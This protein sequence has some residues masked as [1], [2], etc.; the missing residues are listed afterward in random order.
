MIRE[1]NSGRVVPQEVRDK[2]SKSLKGRPHT[3]SHNKKVSEALK[4]K[5]TGELSSAYGIKRSEKTRKR[6]SESAKLGW[7]KRKAKLN[8]TKRTNN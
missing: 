8:D 1:K 6:M 4:G 7:I 3:E 5:Y 2:I